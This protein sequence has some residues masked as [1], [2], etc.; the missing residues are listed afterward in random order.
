MGIH[1]TQFLRKPFAFR[2][3]APAEVKADSLTTKPLT[4]GDHCSLL[5]ADQTRADQ[6]FKRHVFHNP[7]DKRSQ[8]GETYYPT[9]EEKQASPIL[10]HVAP[11][12]SAQANPYLSD[13]DEN[14][15]YKKLSRLSLFTTFNRT[16]ASLDPVLSPTTTFARGWNF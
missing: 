3:P 16:R 5:A 2:A 11:V 12:F 6:I 1:L 14:D 15:H 7:N 10:S 4:C 8:P 9:T 13:F